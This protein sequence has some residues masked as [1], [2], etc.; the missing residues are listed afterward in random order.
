MCALYHRTFITLLCQL[1]GPKVGLALKRYSIGRLSTYHVRD[2]N[3]TEQNDRA[4]TQRL[5]SLATSSQRLSDHLEYKVGS[6]PA[7]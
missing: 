1:E 2:L 4:D 3:I 5:S 6:V 7:P